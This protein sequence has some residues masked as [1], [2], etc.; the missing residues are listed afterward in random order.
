MTFTVT[1]HNNGPDPATGV[2]VADALPSGLDFVGL[3]PAPTV[4]SYAAG[5]WTIG[6]MASGATETLSIV[7]TV[8]SH[9]PQTNTATVSSATLDPNAGNNTDDATV[10]VP[11]A[12]VHVNKTVTDITPP[13]NSDVTFTVSV[14]NTG[15]DTAEA[16]SVADV[17]PPG[18]VL[19]GTPT[20]SVGT[21]A[22]G[23]WTIGDMLNG[24]VETL[25]VTTTVTTELQ[26]TN[27]AAATSS[28]FDPDLDNNTDSSF[29]DVPDVD[30]GV[31]NVVDDPTP[32]LGQNVTFTVTVENHGPLDATGVTVADLLPPGFTFVSATPPSGTTYSGGVWTIGFLGDDAVSVMTITATV[33]VHTPLTTTATVDGDQYDPNPLNDAESAG[34]DV[35]DADLA[36]TKSVDNA[37]AAV[38]SNVTFTLVATNNGPDDAT[39]VT[40]ADALPAGLTFVSA[41]SPAYTPGAGT[42]A[43]GPLT[44]GASTTLT[45]VATVVS[46]TALTN[47]ATISSELYDPATGDNTDDASVDAPDA[48]LAVTKTVSTGTPAL[49]DAVTFTVTVTNNGV[50]TATGTSVNDPLPSGLTLVS[51]TPSTGT[52]VGGLWTVGALANGASETLTITATVTS[53]LAITNTATASSGVYDP[54]PGDNTASAVVNV[55]DADLEV[56]KTVNTA[57]PTLNGAATFTVTVTNHGPNAATGVSVADTLP[58]GLTLVSATPSQG[59]FASG[60]WS[61]GA[62]A[63]GATATLALVTTVTDHLAITNTATVSA[64]T[65]DPNAAN[66]SANA[67]VNVPD[68]NLAV[69]KVV[70]NPTPLLG[71]DVT[72]TVTATNLGPDDATGVSVADALPGGLTLV[73][74]TPSQGS[75]AAGVWTVDALANTA[76]ATL[77]VVA[78]VTSGAP[79]T[80]TATIS[81][82]QYDPVSTNNSSF[83]TVGARQADLVVTKTVDTAA[84]ALNGTV[85]FTVSVRNA[86]PDDTTG[87]VVNDPLPAGL[88]FGSAATA[89]GS[90]T[91]ATGVWNVG[92]LASG[93]T[94]TLQITATVTDHLALTNT[95]SATSDLYDPLPGNNSAAAVVDVPDADLSLNKSVNNATPALNG[96]VVF[97]IVVANTGPSAAQNVTVA[98]LLPSG[99]SFVSSDAGGGYDAGT[100]VWTVGSIGSGATAT[101]N[102]TATV[103]GHSAITNSAT[104]SSTTFD[105]ATANNTDDATVDV[106]DANLA[107]TK[108]VSNAT[109]TVGTDVTFTVTVTNNGPETAQSVLVSDLLPSGLTFVSS[110]AGAAYISGTGAW[111]VGAL[112][113]GASASI[114][115]VATVTGHTAIT[116]TATA[117][118]T[119]HDPTPANN[120]A[121][122]VVNAR[123]ADLVV[124]KT[125][126]TPT[127]T[128]GAT[129]TFTVTVHN[130]GPDTAAAT[131]V[132]DAL[133]TGLTFVSATPSVGSYAAGV[134]SVG[135]LASSV[136]ETL[137][138]VAT[139]D[140]HTA[141]TNSA[142]ASS[143]TFDPTPGNNTGSAVIN[144][145]D[146]DLAV[147]KTVSTATPA[148]GSNVTFTVTATNSGPDAASGVSVSDLLPPGLTFVSATPSAGSYVAGTGVW[149]VGALANGANA[150]LDIVATVTQYTAITNT[151]TISG[152]TLDPNPANNTRS[153]GVD[154]PNA[155]LTLTKSVSTA[156]PAL[157]SDVT[158]TL[159][160]TNNGPDLA[161]AV[162]VADVL[163][164]GL[165]YVSST[166]FGGY[167]PGTGIWTVGDLASGITVTVDVTATVTQR[168]LITNSATATSAT[169]DPAPADNTDEVDVRV[170]EADIAVTKSVD[171]A[172]PA[173]GANVTFTIGVTN[174]G[175]DTADA[176]S[177]ADLLPSGLSFVSASPSVGSYNSGTGAWSV[178]ALTSGASAT[179]DI[180]ATATAHLPVTNTATGTTTTLDPVAGNN[181]ASIGVNARDADLAI[182]KTVSDAAPDLGTAVTFTVAVTNNGPDA[183]TGVAVADL[184]PAGLTFVSASSG[185]YND[186]T[187]VWTIGGL[188]NGATTSLDIVATVT[189]PSPITNVATVTS[190]SFDPNT[191]NNS[192]DAVVNTRVA[193]LRLTKT[194]NAAAPAMGADV[195]FTIA[196][197]NDGPD[198]AST[199]AVN[200]L[201]PAGL[202]FVSASS[203]T[204][205]AGTG[206][207]TLSGNATLATYR[208][209][210]RSVAYSSS[211]DDPTATSAS[212]T[213]TRCS[214]C[215]PPRGSPAAD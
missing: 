162:S 174:N 182:T 124:T 154:V 130:N 122:V 140:D 40:V 1:V 197:T 81:G 189:Q 8:R 79:Q 164:A 193:D 10:D 143:T 91:A 168:G 62:M 101:I 39:T 132:A 113:N 13:M 9:L 32:T 11:D 104:V 61:V 23:V 142:T 190:T 76:S 86:G 51:A 165:T 80:N 7:A 53:H 75:Y 50:D 46:H 87:V 67:S 213:V 185:T 85:T 120:S 105:P 107:V 179:L 173:V 212:R 60:V 17:L 191:G 208:T 22:A 42:W 34:V 89:T 73:S 106:P 71:T 206:V 145:P 5:V 160:L 150:T 55:P 100:G 95:A 16:V 119:T 21:F 181:S 201:L 111:T 26:T 54:T 29:V 194:V 151:A 27:T 138:I 121:N 211:S 133:P 59:T 200:D 144:V 204:Y 127:P 97:T 196:V 125:V 64:T 47:T 58:A 33:D 103:T 170:P 180:V 156:T 149:M 146:A 192:D 123:D 171:N 78:T 153:A 93:V 68:T 158:Y 136:T 141:I 45:I 178:G 155:D 128:L 99:L 176:V 187:G 57:T 134:W 186:G 135:A 161:Q 37:T 102:I 108:T 215:H 129:V 2:T 188:G 109:P 96:N 166:P 115:I 184:L 72:F 203:G 207:L 4:G 20:T 92:D 6:T 35:P 147:T 15:P 148:L 28:T 65:V 118:S 195:T 209:L 131:S 167:A 63:N 88:V 19:Q 112:A 114:Q 3:T 152:T 205:N 30:L 70:D 38:G 210:L 139:V 175:P 117:S 137:D 98:D 199:V 14:T 25:T 172:T 214:G 159:S 183:A 44:S 77:T 157:G 48:D 12:N 43:V 126:N 66:N 110:D 198:T 83:A 18:L 56:T 94:A 49:G 74:A 177:V 202:T 41:S 90:Y 163:P 36:I 24:A 31:E 116:N 169:H 52:Y 82:A 69:T 84:P